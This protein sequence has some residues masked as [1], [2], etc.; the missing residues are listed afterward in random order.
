MPQRHWHLLPLRREAVHGSVVS[1]L[2]DMGGKAQ[3]ALLCRIPER[4]QHP[5]NQILLQFLVGL[6]ALSVLRLAHRVHLGKRAA[7]LSEESKRFIP[8]KHAWVQGTAVLANK[9]AQGLPYRGFCAEC[10]Q[11]VLPKA[12]MQCG[13]C[14]KHAHA[15]CAKKA[16]LGCK[17]TYRSQ[18]DIAVG[19]RSKE[20]ELSR[21][22]ATNPPH[23]WH[24]AHTLLG[25]SCACCSK[26][27]QDRA[28]HRCNWCH[29]E[30][31]EQC[32]QRAQSSICSLGPHR[33]LLLP[34]AA[35]VEVQRAEP[36][37][38]KA[39]VQRVQHLGQSHEEA[40]TAAAAEVTAQAA[41]QGGDAGNATWST[42]VHELPQKEDPAELALQASRRKGG[43]R[44]PPRK[45]QKYRVTLRVAAAAVPADLTPLAVLVNTRVSKLCV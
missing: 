1:A 36:S 26:S 27:F 41:E 20:P 39:V 5:R 33:K 7:K 24:R 42:L 9:L 11:P 10:S 8:G 15:K 43:R 14:L 23:N 30:V 3:E 6:L 32:L 34:P 37:R 17:A 16:L 13:I 4:M 18:L 45:L 19:S 29:A 2:W 21:S 44:A 25:R 22:L 12:S 31:H 35:I 38:L 28:V 40:E